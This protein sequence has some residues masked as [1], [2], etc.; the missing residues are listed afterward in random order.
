MSIIPL[1]LVAPLF[2]PATFAERGAVDDLLRK[3]RSDYPLSQAEVPGFDRHWIVTRYKDIQHIS[4]QNDLFHNADRSATLAPL[5]GEQ[6]V[7]EFTGGDYNLF[8]SLVQLDGKEH[9]AH[10]NVLRATLSPPAIAE[11]ETRLRASAREEVDKLTG[12]GRDH[13]FRRGDRHPLP[14]ARGHGHHRRAPRGPRGYA[15]A[16][17]VAVLLGRP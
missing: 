3:L 2:N 1:E 9:R 13:R 15:G 8:R 11:M 16:D 17:P 5:I 4:R 14:P 7:R 6:L 10:R 12:T